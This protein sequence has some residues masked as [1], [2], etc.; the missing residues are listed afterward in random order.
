MKTGAWGAGLS[1][2]GD[3]SPLACAG[4]PGPA[5][6]SRNQGLRQSQRADFLVSQG[7]EHPHAVVG[8]VRREHVPICGGRAEGLREQSRDDNVGIDHGSDHGRE[9]MTGS[10]G[11]RAAPFAPQLSPRRSHPSKVDSTRLGPR[12]PMIAGASLARGRVRALG[13]RTVQRIRRMRAPWLDGPTDSS[14][15]EPTAPSIG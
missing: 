7:R 2:R 3:L 14:S 6:C 5:L 9:F 1:Q 10:A 4:P 15:Q 11:L 12:S 13:G 8:I